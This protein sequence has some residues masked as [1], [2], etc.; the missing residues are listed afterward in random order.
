MPSWEW[1]ADYYTL[2]LLTSRA[3]AAEHKHEP[4][5]NNGH[6][7]VCRLK[8]IHKTHNSSGKKNTISW[9]CLYEGANGSGFLERVE[10]HAQCP[11][12]IICPYEPKDK[13]PSI[14]DMLG[15]MKDAFK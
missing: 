13:P 14:G 6:L 8:K 12:D 11:K 1:R 7:T 5:L 9:W 4:T 2:L 3:N 10:S 15:A